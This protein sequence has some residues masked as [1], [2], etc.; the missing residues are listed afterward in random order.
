MCAVVWLAVFV[1]SVGRSR[2]R[3]VGRVVVCACSCCLCTGVFVFV[4]VVRVL[5]F[6]CLLGYSCLCAFVR[7]IE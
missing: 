5:V 6:A 3:L 7:V 4:F 2:G 1:R